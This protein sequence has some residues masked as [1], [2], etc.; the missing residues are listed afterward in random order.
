M[1]PVADRTSFLDLFLF[2]FGPKYCR[3]NGKRKVALCVAVGLDGVSP[4]GV[5][6]ESHIAPL[7]DGVYIL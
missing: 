7:C 6:D 1:E 2:S 3:G 5:S 4:V